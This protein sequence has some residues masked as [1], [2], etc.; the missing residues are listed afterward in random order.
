[1]AS[2]LDTLIGRVAD[3]R[4][5]SELRAAA[6]D[7]RRTKDFGLVF[8]SHIPERVRL[9]H[10]PIRRGVKVTYRD[11]SDAAI[12]EIVKVSG[13]KASVR[14]LRTAEDVALSA[15]QQAELKDETVALD[16]LVVIAEFGDPIYPG[17]HALGSVSRGGDRPAHV[18]INGENH[19]ALE[20]L[21][22][23]HAGKVDCI[24]ID[25]PYNT[26]ARDWKYSND[27][28]DTEDAY[29]HSKWLAFMERRLRLAKALLNPDDSVL[30]CTIDE[31]EV[32][33][34][35][36]LLEQ[37]FPMAR[38]QMVSICINPSG[39]SGQSLSRVGEYA[40]F[41]FFGQATPVPT[42]D[43]M[44]SPIVESDSAT[45]QWESLL[46]RGNAWYRQ[47]RRNLCYP[48]AVDP[49]SLRVVDIGSPL[50][51]S[52][53]DRPRQLDGFPL[54]WPVRTDGRLGIWR[55]D[56]ARL[57]SLVRR[58]YA[59]VSSRDDARDT[60]TIKYLMS[61]TINEIEAGSIVVTGAGDRGQVLLQASNRRNTTAKTI[62]HRGRH[63]AGGAGGTQILNAFLGEKNL[64]PFPKSVY[65]V[66]D[67]LAVALGNRP[68]ALVVDFFAGS[69]TTF[70][71]AAMLNAS[72]GGTRQSVLVTNNGNCSACVS[73][74]D[75]RQPRS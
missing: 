14:R 7:L 36:V 4:L 1:V 54:A 35:G 40:F 72:D 57:R 31:I 25:P 6:A 3:E 23:T 41:C 2:A 65:A 19:H 46:R 10:H 70:H 43:D 47:S 56:G 49:E 30:V 29:R 32:H 67:C 51:G 28:V 9:P 24:Y 27:Y 55:V 15:Q 18:V 66:R 69:G 63:T 48:V 20:A 21:A 58:G 22:F 75:R 39:A 26:G 60:W 42:P 59:Y 73:E 5:R 11:G 16:A 38:R 45:V 17:L 53:T 33:H 62:W 12:F 68:A 8:E 71:A 37:V 74:G 13:S 44:L 64:F 34:L 50:A 52:D 61:G